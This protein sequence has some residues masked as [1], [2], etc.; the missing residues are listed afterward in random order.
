M[1]ENNKAEDDGELEKLKEQ[2]GEYLDN[3]KRERANFVNYKNEE[4][5]RMEEFSRFSST[6]LILEILEIVD[7]IETV[8][9]NVP[10]EKETSAG[11]KVI[12]K[13]LLD[14]LKKHG[15]E[16]IKAENVKFDPSLHE[17]VS[18]EENGDKIEE[19]RSGYTI[20]GRVIRPTRV[21]I[22]K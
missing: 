4:A 16:R 15:V 17:A 5:K 2:A 3:W 21:K 14:L 22:I 10:T 7:D 20:Y 9:K 19:V 13:K 12:T 11:L 6:G 18:T 8:L 1:E